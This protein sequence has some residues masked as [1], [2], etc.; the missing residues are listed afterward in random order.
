M[1]WHILYLIVAGACLVLIGVGSVA[2][3]YELHYEEESK[4]A[5][6]SDP[7]RPYFEARREYWERLKTR[8]LF[9]GF[10]LMLLMLFGS[11][12]VH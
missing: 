7:R 3:L 10:V 11:L 5:L 12:T 9:P 4:F 6:C 1:V 2:G 8:T